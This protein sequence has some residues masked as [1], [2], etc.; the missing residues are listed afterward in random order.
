MVS[1]RLAQPGD[2]GSL[3]ALDTLVSLNPWS[4][5]RF[6]RACSNAQPKHDHAL[7]SGS[8]DRLDGFVVFSWVLD[9]ASIHNIAVHPSRQREGLGRALLESALQHLQQA[10]VRRCLLEVRVSNA[11]ARCLYEGRGFTLDCVR[12]NYYPTADGREDALLMSLE[13]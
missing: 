3:A 12:K 4:E 10:G 5:R 2:A 6:L 1:I 7:V 11:A 13:L 9:E 8:C